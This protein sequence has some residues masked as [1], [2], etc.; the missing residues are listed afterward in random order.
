MDK[1]K[2]TCHSFLTLNDN[3]RLVGLALFSWVVCFIKPLIG[4]TYTAW[5]THY[6]GFVNFLYFSD[7]LRD[8]FFPLWNNFIQSGTFFPNLFNVGLF[9]P[10]QLTFVALSWI[11]NPVYIYELMLQTIILI[12][13][14][15]TYLFFMKTTKDKLIS[16]FGAITFAIVFLVPITGQIGFLFSLSSLP[17]MMLASISILENK[18]AGNDLIYVIWGVM[19]G[20]YISSGYP[21]MNCI[22]LIIVTIFSS[23]IAIKLFLNSKNHEKKELYASMMSIIVFLS[24]I[25]LTYACVVLPGYLNML[26]NYHMFFGDYITPEPRLRNLSTGAEHFAY[27]SIYMAIIGAI[28]PR[29]AINNP[30]WLANMPNWSFGAGWILWLLFLALPRKRQNKNEWQT[31]WSILLVLSLLY[32]AGDSNFLG[33]IITNTPIINANRWWFCDVFYSI[34]CLL[35]LRYQN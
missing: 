27:S 19:I 21:W 5:D 9:Y 22:N 25:A 24:S 1:M 16:A 17:W 28:D 18:H 4:K 35:F 8:G 32:S 2:K 7:S 14:I 13:G 6:L 30:Q 23:G 12:A 26:S 31:F 20:M 15:G 33:K 11:I 29:I 34:I 3:T 10:F